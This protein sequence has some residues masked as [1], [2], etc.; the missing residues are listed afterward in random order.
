MPTGE[1][2]V[3]T[4]DF[5]GEIISFP[6]RRGGQEDVC[7]VPGNALR[8]MKLFVSKLPTVKT[9]RKSHFAV[10]RKP[11]PG[12]FYSSNGTRGMLAIPLAA[13]L[14]AIPWVGFSFHPTL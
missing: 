14:R 2:L 4:L 5:F 11:L 13:F 6:G 3:T 12:R 1:D 9:A 7:L 10:N 8:A